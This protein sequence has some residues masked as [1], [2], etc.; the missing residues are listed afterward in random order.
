MS[1]VGLTK[2]HLYL[3]PFGYWVCRKAD[4]WNGAGWTPAKAY[5]NWVERN[6]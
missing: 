2:P 3:S 6:G 4:Q 5:A 1:A